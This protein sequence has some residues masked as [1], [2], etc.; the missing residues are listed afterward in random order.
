[1]ERYWIWSEND[2]IGAS[3]T[4]ANVE[5]VLWW[6]GRWSIVF[7]FFKD[8]GFAK[9]IQ[10]GTSVGNSGS[11]E[12]MCTSNTRVLQVMSWRRVSQ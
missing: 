12:F 6:G 10:R 8:F 5:D 3:Q 9:N 1:M 4:T 11:V 2:K 7:A